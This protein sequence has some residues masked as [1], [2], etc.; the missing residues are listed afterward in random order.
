[1][2]L[3]VI[4]RGGTV[5]DGTGAPSRRA[6][7]GIEG[8]KIALVSDLSSAAAS[9]EIDATGRVVSPGFIDVH[10]HS[11]LT[12]LVN[13]RAESKIRQGVTTG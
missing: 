7:V 6:D 9:V 12:V 2:P 8:E 4:I 1:M 3:D 5:V 11:D 13:G 10:T